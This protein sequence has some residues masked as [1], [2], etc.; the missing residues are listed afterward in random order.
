[1]RTAVTRVPPAVGL[2]ARPPFGEVGGPF[3]RIGDVPGEVRVERMAEGERGWRGGDSGD[4]GTEA[5]RVAAEDVFD[6]VRDAVAVRVVV[7]ILIRRDRGRSRRSMMAKV[8]DMREDL[9]ECETESLP[10][11]LFAS[12]SRMEPKFTLAV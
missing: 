11:L 1:M 8:L 4:A 7:E 10:V 9:P 5:V 2:A 6:A 3:G 12:L